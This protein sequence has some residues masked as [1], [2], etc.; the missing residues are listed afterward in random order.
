MT[1]PFFVANPDE[2]D[3]QINLGGVRS[4]LA[5]PLLKDGAVVGQLVIYR[6]EPGAFPE[7]QVALLENFAAQ[8]V[9]AMENA[10]LLDE[11]RQRQEE[12]R[13]TFE[14]MGDGVALF[15]AAHRL[16]AW[17]RRFQD[18]L[19]LPD[20]VLSQGESFADYIRTLATRGE[21]GPVADAD[22]Q[23]QHLVALVGEQ[24]TFERARPDGRTVE[25][26]N[27]P[28]ADGGFVL[29][30]ADI[31]E[32]KRAEA[33][34]A[35]A[36]DAAEQAARTIEAAYRELK[37]AQANLVQAEKMASLGQLT[38]GIAHEIKNPLNFV[39]NFSE[40][41]VDL[42][43]E[44]KESA[45]P[46]FARWTPTGAPT[47]TSLRSCSPATWKR[48]PNTAAAPTASCAA[49]WN[50]HGEPPASGAVSISTR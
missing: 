27:N 10:R 42:L 36:R 32:R 13:V 24:R 28:V 20:D 5:L 48:S 2:R 34:I 26:R 7:K 46:G 6:K 22:E 18:I 9:I 35:A 15:D 23:V 11:I 50:I 47:S 12:L 44:L 4:V 8:A 33:E 30:Y 16:V 31:T 25:V 38:A 17:N 21:F 41:S 29:I 3:A 14:N 1:H 49:C 45:A 43:D 39:N 19:D 37:T 40:L